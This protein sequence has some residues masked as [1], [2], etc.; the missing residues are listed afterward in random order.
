MS[1]PFLTSSTNLPSEKVKK[2]PQFVQ[3][4]HE[5]MNAPSL[6]FKHLASVDLFSAR[7]DDGY[8]AI[9]KRRQEGYIL[10]RVGKRD[11][12]YRWVNQD[13]G[14]PQSIELPIEAFISVAPQTPDG[15]RFVQP[16]K[17][18]VSTSAAAINPAQ[19]LRVGGIY[20]WDEIKERFDWDSDKNATTCERGMAT[21]QRQR[22]CGTPQLEQ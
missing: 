14:S 18:S 21:S 19:S 8:R 5:N 15:E 20:T 7:L 6:H 10:L 1:L 9:L 16:E 4:L 17:H 11:E 3:M 22:I 2:I 12:T 13:C